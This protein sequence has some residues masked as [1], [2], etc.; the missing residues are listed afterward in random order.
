[1]PF[2]G[3]EAVATAVFSVHS[4]YLWSWNLVDKMDTSIV[5]F[6]TVSQYKYIM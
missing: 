2:E 3:K 1:M 6:N 4:I 5:F